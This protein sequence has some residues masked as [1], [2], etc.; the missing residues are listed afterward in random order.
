MLPPLEYSREETLRFAAEYKDT[1]RLL[2]ANA[3]FERIERAVYK[4]KN[5]AR[6]NQAAVSNKALNLKGKDEGFG[7]LQ[8]VMGVPIISVRPACPCLKRC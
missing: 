1:S 7:R 5:R 3:S 4:H 6:E 2:K 8:G